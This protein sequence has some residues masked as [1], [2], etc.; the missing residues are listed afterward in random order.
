MKR[1]LA[2]LA[3]GG[4]VVGAATAGRRS[5]SWEMKKR[6]HIGSFVPHD[7]EAKTHE[8]EHS[9]VTHNRRQGPDKMWGEWEHLTAEHAHTH[10]HPSLM[11]SHLPHESAEHEHLG[12]AHVHDHSHP[13]S[14]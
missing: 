4:A 12:E 8:H 13:A 9:H 3:M 7:H 1:L 6:A 10:N 5:L 14:S 11:H 2:F